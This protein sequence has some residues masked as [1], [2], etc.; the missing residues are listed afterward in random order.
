MI[1]VDTVIG[2]GL[3]II[4]KWIPDKDAQAKAAAEYESAVLA[5]NTQLAVSQNEVNKVEAGHS[6]IFVS[7]WRPFIGWICGSALAYHF[8]L[9]PLIVFLFALSGEH[10]DLPIF[11]MD[12]LYTV[13]MGI[14]G[15]G[16][17]RSIE[18]LKGVARS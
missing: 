2:E 18:K 11:D 10:V 14:L 5:A 4:N 12:A 13:L 1:G 3:K 9:Q 6:S 7:G 17:F 15:L 16:G 8:I